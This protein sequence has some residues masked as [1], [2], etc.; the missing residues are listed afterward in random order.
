MNCEVISGGRCQ[1]LPGCRSTKRMVFPGQNSC[2]PAKRGCPW[3]S[4]LAN[5]AAG[6]L[7]STTVTGPFCRGGSETVHRKHSPS[8][9]S[10]QHTRALWGS[11]PAPGA[12][13]STSS[14]TRGAAGMLPQG[15]SSSDSSKKAALVR[16]TRQPS[17]HSRVSAWRCAAGLPA[18][19]SSRACNHAFPLSGAANR[20]CFT[21]KQGSCRHLHGCLTIC[22]SLFRPQTCLCTCRAPGS[23]S[24]PACMPPPLLLR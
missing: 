12:P 3:Q 4:R 17:S 23:L 18:W 20:A 13:R 16:R 10:S 24:S 6:R 22:W 1:T 8:D 19:N 9:L 15:R 7:L 5:S 21:S 11:A 2:A 14:N